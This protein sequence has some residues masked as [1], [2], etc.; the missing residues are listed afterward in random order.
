MRNRVTN[1]WALLYC[2]VFLSGVAGLI[3]QVTWHK[4]LA[5]LLGGQAK[6]TAIV[7][8]I[9]LGGISA[10]YLVFGYWSRTRRW[11]LL[12]A[13]A[14]VE[15]LLAFW[16]IF[17]PQMFHG[18]QFLT[19]AYYAKFGVDSLAIDVLVSLGLL[20]I[21]T[22]LMGGTLPLL[23][24]GL[25]EDLKTASRTHAKIYG[26][27]TV[28][29]CFGAL[30][31][32]Y[33]L[34]PMTDLP[35][36]LLTAVF[37]NCIAGGVTYFAYAKHMGTPKKAPAK[38]KRSLPTLNLRVATLFVVGFLSGFYVLTLENVFIR[39]I[40]L[41]TGSSNY[42]FTLVVA[43]FVLALGTGSL[44]VRRIGEFSEKHLVWNQLGVSVS[45]LALYFT[46]EFWP[47]WVHLIRI[48]F[49][50]IGPN[51]YVYQVALAFGFLLLFLVPI[52][53][54]GLTLPLCF[55]LLKDKQETLGERVGQL[56]GLN[57]LGCVL[58]AS[59]GGYWILHFMN[60]DQLFRL[61]V[62][63]VLLG[64]FFA[65]W[66]S[67]KNK[68]MGKWDG[69]G[70]AVLGV[71]VLV[72]LIVAPNTDKYMYLQMFR[73]QQPLPNSYEGRQAMSKHLQTRS[74]YLS[75]KD[76][77]NTSVAVSESKGNGD[78]SRSLIVNGKSDGNTSGDMLTMMMT[79]AIPGVLAPKIEKACV[80]GFGTGA[81]V[82]TLARFN[83]NKS[84]DVVEIS[85]TVLEA[86][87]YFDPF[88]G[89]VTKDPKVKMHEMD[90]FRFF[91]TPEKYDIIASE[92][93]NPWVVGV[94]NLFTAE[95][96][97]A[98][99]S[100]LNDDG[101]FVQWIHLYSF[102]DELLKSVF[103]TV[104]S[105]FPHVRVFKMLEHDIALLASHRP[106]GKADLALAERRFNSNPEV[107]KLLKPFGADK[108]ENFLA[109]EIG[110]PSMVREL[111]K[112]LEPL[113]LEMPRLSYQ[114]A[115]AL[116]M[117]STADIFRARKRVSSFPK[118]FK[119]SLLN[120]YLDGKP[121]SF[122]MADGFRKAFCEGRGRSAALCREAV[123]YQ[124]SLKP[125]LPLEIAEPGILNSRA[126]ALIPYF[127]VPKRKVAV[128]K[129]ELAKI[130]NAVTLWEDTI[131]PIATL[132][133]D[134]LMAR[135]EA[136]D[137][138]KDQ[139]TGEC[140]L[141]R[142]A[143]LRVTE[144]DSARWKKTVDQFQ[145]W[146]QKFPSTEPEHRVFAEVDRAIR[147]QQVDRVPASH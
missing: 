72:G 135:L 4:Y 27:N 130:H 36:A 107:L 45:L 48:T 61:C 53:L 111:G 21:P 18:F 1:S 60:L 94:E 83:E 29:A 131:S 114:A 17:F 144:P 116:F 73:Q 49:R 106:L 9:F 141:E 34:I 102:N 84:V 138:G 142:M 129:N 113:S 74:T 146:F 115:K 98:V 82:G 42:T 117:G 10:G 70:A 96:Y 77:P 35:V 40:G 28:G 39:L 139:L 90:A 30:L 38:Q 103:A 24:Q 100:K 122:A 132:P 140:L 79:G 37:L 55:H 3:Y 76:G 62:A 145:V 137:I 128:D 41:S 13:Y 112:G 126:V 125:S 46:V 8:A 58:G 97:D 68:V 44:L 59:V 124:K 86:A 12:A 87:P 127:E 63:T 11:N 75:F 99:L 109:Y 32:G 31:A 123:L 6:A 52:G 69:G 104:N 26:W 78:H 134:G 20:G 101:V 50:E 89:N 80:I 105:R 110:M 136:C 133:T 118:R 121:V 64:A 22:F 57:T 95:F 147:A 92:P 81:T 25:S 119:E 14:I 93:S 16:G 71:A 108:F 67:W 33:V 7:L 5:I 15:V 51:F 54:C 91:A 47:Y 56:Y 143:L 23:T 120:L 66:A 19:H 85:G 88:N 2:V 65:L 43:I